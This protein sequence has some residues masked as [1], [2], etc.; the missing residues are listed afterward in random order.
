M[1]RPRSLYGGRKTSVKKRGYHLKTMKVHRT[2]AEM[3]TQ[4]AVLEKLAP[5]LQGP[6]YLRLAANQKLL[7]VGGEFDLSAEQVSAWIEI[8]E[9]VQDRM[10][11]LK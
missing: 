1:T 7:K 10:Q 9:A 6:V 8:L 2:T 5:S 4:P 11:R 3:P